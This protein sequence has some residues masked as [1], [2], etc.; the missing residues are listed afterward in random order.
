[1]QQ[2]ETVFAAPFLVDLAQ[3]L[4]QMPFLTQPGR[5]P[6][7]PMWQVEAL[8]LLLLWYSC[9]NVH[10][11]SFQRQSF[12]VGS[13]SSDESK[14]FINHFK[15]VSLQLCS[16]DQLCSEVLISFIGNVERGVDNLVICW[17]RVC[18]TSGGRYAGSWAIISGYQQASRNSANQ[19]TREPDLFVFR[20]SVSLWFLVIGD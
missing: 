11:P 7:P 17:R 13:Y 10:Q 1:M 9:Y 14:S 2:C 15:S 5:E 6:G 20:K 8:P 12:L 19:K 3:V 16:K 4:R 18:L